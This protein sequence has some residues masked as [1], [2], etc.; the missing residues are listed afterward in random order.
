MRD[1]WVILVILTALLPLPAAAQTT[2]ATVQGTITDRSGAFVPGA[3]VT[4]RAT[5]TGF[6]RTTS[7]D[8]R[9]SYTLPFVPVGDYRL[10]VALQGF[11]TVTRAGLRFAIGQETTVDVALEE[12]AIAEEVTVSADTP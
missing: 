4:L 6:V 5:T 3:T 7:S 11:K 2:T 8:M 10:T 12:A 1:L 9:G